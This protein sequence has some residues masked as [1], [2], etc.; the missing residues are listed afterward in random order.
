MLED[1]TGKDFQLALNEHQR[2]E[3]KS[4]PLPIEEIIARGTMYETVDLNHEIFKQENAS[5]VIMTSN[6]AIVVK[7]VKGRLVYDHGYVA[8]QISAPPGFQIDIDYTGKGTFFEDFGCDIMPA[9]SDNRVGH[10]NKTLVVSGREVIGQAEK[11]DLVHHDFN[12]KLADDS[13]F[14]FSQ[15]RYDTANHTFPKRSDGESGIIENVMLRGQNI[16]H[17]SVAFDKPQ[18]NTKSPLALVSH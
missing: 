5:I 10:S 2:T 7:N 6:M 12:G 11:K 9:M 18:L 13:R 16:Y 14:L 4:I 8:T 1:S 17:I 3:S 15:I